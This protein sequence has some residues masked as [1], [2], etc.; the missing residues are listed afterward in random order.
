MARRRPL[1]PGAHARERQRPGEAQGGRQVVGAARLARLVSPGRAQA[2]HQPEP[3]LGRRG[4]QLGRAG[5]L[6][7]QDRDRLR[8]GPPVGPVQDLGGQRPQA[9]TLEDLP[10][11]QLDAEVPA[12]PGDQARRQ[13]GVA[14]EGE[15]A[16]ADAHPLQLQQL[17]PEGRHALLGGGPGRHEGGRLAF[18]GALRRRQGVAVDLAAGQGRQAVEEHD[19][20][21]DQGLRQ[22]APEVG[23]QLGLGRGIVGERG[24]DGVG[25]QPGVDPFAPGHHGGVGHRRVGRQGRFHLRRLDPVAPDLHLVVPPADE[26]EAAVRKVPGQVAGAVQARA[27]FARSEVGERIGDE[28][29]GGEGRAP[30]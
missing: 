21:G 22:Q 16:V 29:L 1:E 20:P 17:A 7:G 26:V 6:P 23:Q 5:R 12:H 24:R 18:G 3:L 11:R 30:E 13:Q 9:R 25:H 8:G 14:A 28:A 27:R 4:G 10:Q 2:L 15:E 19:P